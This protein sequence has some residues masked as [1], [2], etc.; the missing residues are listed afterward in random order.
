MFAMFKA[1][2]EDKLFTQLGKFSQTV[3]DSKGVTVR[4]SGT[5]T[6]LAV[7]PAWFLLCRTAQ[8]NGLLRL[9][10]AF[11]LQITRLTIV[12]RIARDAGI[13]EQDVRCWK[14]G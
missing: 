14:R 2:S 10:S 5:V 3:E 12:I 4:T 7:F 13:Q 1:Q 6:F 9:V 8:Y 11:S